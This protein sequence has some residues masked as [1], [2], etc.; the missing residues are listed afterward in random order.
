MKKNRLVI[1]AEIAIFASIA[2][3]LDALQGG[4]SKAILPFLASGGSIG[5]A[6]I[7]IFIIAYRRGLVPGL[8]C[9]LIVSITQMLSSIYIINNINYESAFMAA[10]GPF[11]QI[12]FDYLLAY[13]AVGVAGV[14]AKKFTETKSPRFLIY[15]VIIGGGLKYICHV[16]SGGLF[17]L[18]PTGGKTIFGIDNS[19]W[20]FSIIYNLTYM[21]PN[22]LIAS[23]VMPLL[24]KIMPVL[25]NPEY[26]FS[27]V[28]EKVISK[29]RFRINLIFGIASFLVATLFLIL[30][31]S[32]YEIFDDGYGTSLGSKGDY[33]AYMMFFYIVSFI[34][35]H[36]MFLNIHGKDTSL[37]NDVV[38]FMVA[39]F[40]MFAYSIGEFTRAMVKHKPFLDNMQY[41][42]IF[43]IA[44]ILTIIDITVYRYRKNKL[45]YKIDEEA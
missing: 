10:M 42:F 29:K 18:D 2:F 35:L 24:N 15:G 28:E 19:S 32:N 39:I 5:I 22:I 23:L 13:T 20:W 9:G 30:F 38:A 1:M 41:V 40:F 8:I 45:L 37:K 33:L 14:F 36:K 26:N 11:L 43:S 44:I 16:I 31:V 34:L 3:A 4:I 6:M 21:L 25:L 7:P 27:V 17:W 12:M